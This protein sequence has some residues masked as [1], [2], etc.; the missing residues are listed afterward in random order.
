MASPTPSC[1]RTPA[2]FSLPKTRPTC[3]GLPKRSNSLRT[4]GVDAS[5]IAA[6][7]NGESLF[8]GEAPKA[9]IERIARCRKGAAWVLGIIREGWT[10]SGLLHTDQSDQVSTSSP[11]SLA[12][13]CRNL[14]GDT[15][16]I[17]AG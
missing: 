13:R 1:T 14:P 10:I 7:C 2:C 17:Y 12:S 16:L 6:W 15:L 5:A 4:N 3:S 11:P 9:A 8:H